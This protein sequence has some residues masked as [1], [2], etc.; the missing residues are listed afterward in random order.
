M[1]KKKQVFFS[2]K[3]FFSEKSSIKISKIRKTISKGIFCS[4]KSQFFFLEISS[5]EMISN[6]KMENQNQ[7]LNFAQTLEH[8]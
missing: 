2:Q 3:F 1:R 6:Q 4:M 8:Y 7:S 5:N